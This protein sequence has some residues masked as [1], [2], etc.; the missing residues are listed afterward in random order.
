LDA[1]TLRT[2]LREQLPAYMVPSDWLFPDSFPLTPNGK[3]DRAALPAPN[4][5]QRA[6]YTAPSTPTGAKLAEL[7]AEVLSVERVS[8]D[9]DF[10]DLGG[11]SLLAA[12]LVTRIAQAFQLSVPLPVLFQK[13]TI[14][15]LADYID[16]TLW[17][18]RQGAAP[19]TTLQDDEEEF[20][21]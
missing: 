13:P 3:L 14:E 15:Q 21:L 20:R 2:A 9:D 4:R 12:K 16:T 17:A 6:A 5:Q 19:E 10:F 1:D 11:H 7:M 18:A 8:A